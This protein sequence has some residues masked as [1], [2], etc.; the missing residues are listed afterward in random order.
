[1]P[2]RWPEKIFRRSPDC[3]SQAVLEEQTGGLILPERFRGG[4][5]FGGAKKYSALSCLDCFSKVR[6]IPDE[7]GFIQ[8]IA[9]N[10]ALHFG[11]FNTLLWNKLGNP[12]A[13]PA[14]AYYCM[15]Q[16]A[17]FYGETLMPI[18]KNTRVTMGEH[19]EKF[20]ASHHR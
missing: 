6:T 5:A 10:F 14:N 17:Q 19:F 13:T 3:L 2:L 8:A 20:P 9:V 11:T 7:Q 4:Y 15:A 16:I 1:V 18:P 12:V